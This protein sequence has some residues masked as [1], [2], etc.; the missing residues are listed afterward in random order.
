[1]CTAFKFGIQESQK[2]ALDPLGLW[3]HIVLNHHMNVGNWIQVICKRK[4]AV[5]WVGEQ[6]EGE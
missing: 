5:I 1:M 4:N 3:L 2:K 6:G